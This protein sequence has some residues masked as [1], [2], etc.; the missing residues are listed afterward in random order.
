MRVEGAVAE[1]RWKWQAERQIFLIGYDTLR[2]DI[3]TARQRNW[4]LVVLDEAQRIKNRQAM[5]SQLCKRL[6]RLRSWALTGTPLENTVDE[7]ASVLE[8]VRSNPAGARVPPLTPG[9]RMRAL[10]Q[11]LQLRRRKADVLPELPRLCCGRRRTWSASKLPWAGRMTDS[12]AE[13]VVL[14]QVG[15]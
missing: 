12:S 9:F 2:S 6:P 11:D 1:R 8:F 10:H 5:I 14:K 13:S 15:I 3:S 7:L 4:D